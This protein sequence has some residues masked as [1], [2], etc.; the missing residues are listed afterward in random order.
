MTSTTIPWFE[1]LT[2]SV[3][4]LGAAAREA[5]TAHRAARAAGAQCSLDRLRPVDGASPS[6]GRPRRFRNG[7]TTGRSS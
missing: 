3:A 1:T 5:R 6:P 2:D 4:A 7:R